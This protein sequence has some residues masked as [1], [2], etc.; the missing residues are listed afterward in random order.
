MNAIEK[1]RRLRELILAK[2]TLVM[3]DAFDALSA[4][5]IESL[6]FP[7]VQCSGFS[8]ALAA[9]RPTE[10][11]LGRDANLCAMAAVGALLKRNQ[12]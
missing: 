11:D 12:R 10:T 5:I 4:R 8:M 9:M 2:E 1:S 3:P 6:G 7:A